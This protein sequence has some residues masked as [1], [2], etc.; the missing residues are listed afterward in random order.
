VQPG[1]WAFKSEEEAA[2][3]LM[4]WRLARRGEGHD[5]VGRLERCAAPVLEQ[6]KDLKPDLQDSTHCAAGLRADWTHA[7]LQQQPLAPGD[8]NGSSPAAQLR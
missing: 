4:A 6:G 2:A 5:E 7:L 3:A 1:Q 8:A